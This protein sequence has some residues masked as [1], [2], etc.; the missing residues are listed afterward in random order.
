MN[1]QELLNTGIQHLSGDYYSCIHQEER[2]DDT[3]QWSPKEGQSLPGTVVS[4]GFLAAA[5][6]E[7]A[8][9]CEGP[10]PPRVG[11]PVEGLETPG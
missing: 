9:R 5:A 4:E 8:G 7:A 11:D 2:D 6:R 1:D 3:L 10:D